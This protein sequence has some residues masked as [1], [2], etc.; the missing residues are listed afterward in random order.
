MPAD[1]ATSLS[2]RTGV[3]D[4][5]KKRGRESFFGGWLGL[6]ENLLDPLYLKV[7]PE[8][9]ILPLSSTVVGGIFWEGEGDF[10]KIRTKADQICQLSQS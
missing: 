9:Y 2:V 1:S 5:Y 10:E 8:P 3:R 7:R 6:Q 4:I